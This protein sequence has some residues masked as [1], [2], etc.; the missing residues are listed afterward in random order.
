MDE[1][2][3]LDA[4]AQQGYRMPPR[5]IADL[6]DAPITPEVSVGPDRQ[7]MLLMEPANLVP[8]E[9]LAQPELRLAGLRFNPRT[10]GPS[11]SPYSIRLTL[12]R[13]AGGSEKVI[14]GLPAEPRLRHVNWSPD[15]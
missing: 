2:R 3:A 12:Q 6:I 10:N 11:R 4:L 9:E 8:I 13:I 7:W 1:P 15:G 14:A 5:A